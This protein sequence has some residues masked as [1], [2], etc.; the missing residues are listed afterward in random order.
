MYAFIEGKIEEKSLDS[1]VINAGGVGYLIMATA[2][3]IAAAGPVGQKARIYTYLAVRED[4]MVLY[5]FA[6]LEEKKM[7]DRL[8]GVSGVGPKLALAVLSN[9]T[10]SDLAVALV[11][12]DAARLSGVPGVGKKTAQRLC[13]EL[14]EKINNEELAATAGEAAPEGISSATV[15]GE[16]VQALIALG[17]QSAE[18]AK[19]IRALEG[20]ADRVEDLVLLALRWLDGRAK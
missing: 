3:A 17:Y 8:I 12:G 7:F 13:L 2:S 1:I 11:T 19:A 20:K 5:G 18:A 15:E 16:A 14:K 4:A 6:S 10:V 9:L